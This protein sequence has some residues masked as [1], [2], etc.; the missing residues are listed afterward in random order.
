MTKI[1][2]IDNSEKTIAGKFREAF[3][4]SLGIPALRSET[5]SWIYIYMNWT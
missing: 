5:K 3:M 4:E 1:N 2:I